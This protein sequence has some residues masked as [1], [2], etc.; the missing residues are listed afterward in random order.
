VYGL[1][2]FLRRALHL[3]SVAADP[4][5]VVP[6]CRYCFLELIKGLN[7]SVINVQQTQAKY[8]PLIICITYPKWLYV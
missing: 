3:P 6:G 7:L 5:P 2:R 8:R 1:W 4:A